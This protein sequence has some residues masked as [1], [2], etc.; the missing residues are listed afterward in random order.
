[1]P[2]PISTCGMT[3][4]V[5]PAVS[6]RMKAL[7]A[8]LPSVTS[9]GCTGS[10]TPRTG[11]GNTRRE[12]AAPRP[13][14][15]ARRETSPETVWEIVMAWPSRLASGSRLF[16][17]R[18]NPH[19]GA[20]AADISRHR[21]VDVGIIRIGRGGEQGRGRHDLA[22]L[23]VAALDHFEIQPRLL[24]LGAGSRGADTFDGGDGAVA[25]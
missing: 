5:F 17:R 13:A 7:G 4:V 6:M 1:M 23:A 19:I 2:C 8:N 11:Q 3:S 22:G 14:R 16:D 25:H 20:A 15:T 21:S 12:P 18:A 9:G 10:F 24:H